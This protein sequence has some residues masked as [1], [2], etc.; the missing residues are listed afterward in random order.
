MLH[1]SFLLALDDLRNASFQTRDEHEQ[2]RLLD[3]TSNA[4]RLCS[5]TDVSVFRFTFDLVVRLGLAT[6]TNSE[7]E[8]RFVRT[9]PVR[10]ATI[11]LLQALFDAAQ[12]GSLLVQTS[13]QL[14][15]P[16][17]VIGE[18][19]DVLKQL[20]APK[21][22][23]SL[24]HMIF[25]LLRIACRETDDVKA[26]A[27]STQVA[28]LRCLR[29]TFESLQFVSSIASEVADVV[30]HFLPGVVAHT[31]TIASK[32]DL[33]SG[34]AVFAA[35]VS[36]FAQVTVMCFNDTV[37]KHE[38]QESVDNADAATKLQN[39][40][41]KHE[42]Q[43]EIDSEID[44]EIESKQSKQVSEHQVRTEHWQ[45]EARKHV[46]NL[47]STGVFAPATVSFARRSSRFCLAL[48]EAAHRL[49]TKCRDFFA[50]TSEAMVCTRTRLL[51]TV[52]TMTQHE[53][54]QVSQ[55]AAAVSASLR[56]MV[57]VDSGFHST[58]IELLRKQLTRLPE[59]LVEADST[60]K[61]ATLRRARTLL[62][63]LAEFKNEMLEA[64]LLC[65]E[66]LLAL[67]EIARV[68]KQP[69]QVLES[70][71][72]REASVGSATVQSSDIVVSGG[73]TKERVVE[74]FLV[75]L[76][77]CDDS[78]SR[79][80]LCAL[81]HNFGVA[82]ESSA[83][84]ESDEANRV[85]TCVIGLAVNEICDASSQLTSSE[86]ETTLEQ[87]LCAMLFVASK[88]CVASRQHESAEEAMR[89]VLLG[90][91]PTLR[92]LRSEQGVALALRLLASLA[93]GAP[94][95][96][97]FRFVRLNLFEMLIFVGS[98]VRHVALAAV[99]SLT[100]LA[101]HCQVASLPALVA[102]C[103]DV[104]VDDV[105]RQLRRGI[106]QQQ[107]TRAD[108]HA[109]ARMLDAILVLIKDQEESRLVQSMLPAMRV[110]LQTLDLALS[111]RAQ[112]QLLADTVVLVAQATRR[113]GFGAELET[114]L[115][116]LATQVDSVPVYLRLLT[117]MLHALRRHVAPDTVSHND[118]V[119][120]LNDVAAEDEELPHL[121]VTHVETANNDAACNFDKVLDEAV[122]AL[123]TSQMEQFEVST[124]ELERFKQEQAET[125]DHS[126]DHTNEPDDE[127]RDPIPEEQIALDI[128]E[129]TRHA[130]ADG[131]SVGATERLL[132]QQD[133]STL[134]RL[135]GRTATADDAHHV[136]TLADNVA[137]ERS[138]RRRKAALNA[139]GAA[140][141][142][143]AV[144]G[145]HEHLLPAV[146]D[147]WPLLVD[148]L[149]NDALTLQ[150]RRPTKEDKQE[151][152]RARAVSLSALGAF[153]VLDVAASLAGD[154]LARRF[155]T[156]L[157]P[158]LRRLLT[159]L[160][161]HVA[162]QPE[163]V[164]ER[165]LNLL[166]RFVRRCCH[167]PHLLNGCVHDV[168]FMLLPLL[169][170]ALPETVQQNAARA[171]A[172]VAKHDADA[173]WACCE[174]LHQQ[175]GNVLE[176]ELSQLQAEA[177]TLRGDIPM[178]TSVLTKARR[179]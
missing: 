100:L 70:V 124:E 119:P 155:A 48:I 108:T 62:C 98:P 152:L 106:Q 158:V 32:R 31:A 160:S 134:Q 156:Q 142:L 168:I 114:T 113:Y 68:S 49:L 164:H 111:P 105:E 144:C 26:D 137:R 150:R 2:K 115:Q 23:A 125:N 55:S 59:L 57:E 116:H 52:L 99:S 135:L 139:L 21:F 64:M 65:D 77:V 63:F 104:L 103:A 84:S 102:Q 22:R 89:E 18:F 86:S 97:L 44:S 153:S 73:E 37:L 12:R 20:G 122:S 171:C 130:L 85:A 29:T 161:Q 90:V 71:A 40:L 66:V 179:S 4:L 75:P 69:G 16:P 129:R 78:S 112:R 146:A 17:E 8:R 157:L 6:A 1:P 175:L 93:A 143:L 120:L 94:R 133:A 67:T 9:E 162:V 36:L 41:Q 25:L 109:C 24:G 10:V 136:T 30:A 149:D 35:A 33:Q 79:F 83:L 166:L 92:K 141:R 51:Q 3:D 126:I 174:L 74:F 72:L 117:R 45:A 19:H 95:R 5:L 138:L 96:R 60:R 38:A 81:L 61:V 47:I 43:S 121:V 27:K 56:A 123:D 163:E 151:Q 58:L 132:V 7:G 178:H 80:E 28:A 87:R 101:W 118:A 54:P 50:E 167:V 53:L 39:L 91:L 176:P 172:Q 107:D 46:A 169:D 110:L 131:D 34:S 159:A 145:Q 14:Q 165:L 42:A 140:L 11:R 148:I 13:R 147:V 82:F 170:N 173:I 76:V 127:D 154:F 88:L 15:R 177:T 128:V